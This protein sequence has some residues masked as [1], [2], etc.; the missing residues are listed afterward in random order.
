MSL[1]ISYHTVILSTTTK[2]TTSIHVQAKLREM[3]VFG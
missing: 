3:G 1:C 2:T